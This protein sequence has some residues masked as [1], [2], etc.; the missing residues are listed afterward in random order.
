M[1]ATLAGLAKSEFVKVMNCKT[2]KEMWDKLKNIN[3]GY[4]KVK[5]A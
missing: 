1:N 3:E 5:L 2:A 4:G